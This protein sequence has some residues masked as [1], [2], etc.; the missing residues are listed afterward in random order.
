APE[1][2][3]KIHDRYIVRTVLS[4]SVIVGLVLLALSAFFVF[5][6]E[7]KDVGEG[8]YGV[9]QALLFITLNVPR[10]LYQL[11]PVIALLG[12][13]IGLGGLASGSEIVVLRTS[14]VTIR[15]LAVSSLLAGLV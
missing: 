14:G 7:L 8:G 15:R 10:G 4:A 1:Q 13:L 2:G 12:A 9:L 3:M 6:G 11:L 5:I